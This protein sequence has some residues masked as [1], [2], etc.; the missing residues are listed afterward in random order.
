M[1]PS[2]H[3]PL[4]R[5]QPGQ[6]T[7]G[8]VAAGLGALLVLVAIVAGLPVLLSI[9]APAHLPTHAP[10]WGQIHDALLRPDDGSLFLGSLKVVAWTGWAWLVLAV[11]V[12]TLAALRGLPAPR[13]P[14]LG[15]AQPAAAS[16]IATITVLLSAPTGQTGTTA[17]ARAVATVL[18]EIPT[19]F[20]TDP[21]GHHGTLTRPAPP[22][23]APTS[24]PT[25]T[26]ASATSR[27]HAGEG[28]LE[29]TVHRGETLWSLAEKHLGD[30]TRF[31]EI[32]HANYGRPQPD[33]RT[34]TETH[35][36]RPGW[37]LRIPG[38]TQPAAQESSEGSSPGP[39]Q[40]NSVHDPDTTTYVVRPGDTLWDIAQTHL[41]DGTRYPQIAQD[42]RDITQPDGAHLQDPDLIRPG[43][44]LRLPHEQDH[45]AAGQDPAT[46][47]PKAAASAPSTA[48]GSQRWQLAIPDPVPSATSPA[49]GHASVP[50]PSAAGR[51]APVIPAHPGVPIVG[52]KPPAA[53]SWPASVPTG[54]AGSGVGARE[55]VSPQIPGDQDGSPHTDSD[56]EQGVRVPGGWMDYPMAAA[57]AI[58]A[59]RVWLW[60]RHRHAYTPEDLLTRPGEGDEDLVELPTVITRSR[61]VVRAHAPALLDPPDPGPTVAEYLAARRAHSA[62]SRQE[63]TGAIPGLV[64]PPVGPDALDLTGL[65]AQ[66][67]GGITLGGPGA[68]D[69]ARALLVAAVASGGVHDPFAGTQVVIP[70]DLASRLLAPPALATG[71]LASGS[72]PG[73]EAHEPAPS[74][75]EVPEVLGGVERAQVVADL[76]AGLAHVE[77]ELVERR[78]TL[79]AYQV[80]DRVELHETDP[81]AEPMPLLILLTDTPAPDLCERL[82]ALSGPGAPAGISIVVLGDQAWHPGT[83]VDVQ[84]DGHL[85][86]HEPSED[87]SGANG[88]GAGSRVAVLNIDAAWQALAAL[89][90]ARTGVRTPEPENVPRN[91][92][93]GS[94]GA[95]VI[96][97]MNGTAAQLVPSAPAEPLASVP[98]PSA[99]EPSAAGE[100]PGAG[101]VPD[102]RVRVRVLGSPVIWDRDGAPVT[103]M[104]SRAIEIMVLL[105]VRRAGSVLNNIMDALW[106]AAT[107]TQASQC[108]STE[109]ARLRKAIRQ[110]AGD[111]EIQPVVNTGS[112]YHLNPEVVRVDLWDFTDA[113]R[114]AEAEQI[115]GPGLS[116]PAGRRARRIAALREALEIADGQCLADGTKY[117]WIAGPRERVR[118]LLLR[119]HVTLV[120]LLTEAGEHAEAAQVVLAAVDLDPANEEI[121]R[122]A[123]SA[124]AAAGRG[125]EIPAQ[126]RRLRTV[127]ED[128]D[129]EPSPETTALAQRLDPGPPSPH[130]DRM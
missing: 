104:R 114:R 2:T 86:R 124:L 55:S 123:M 38:A 9:V 8:D 46:A 41:G 43:W 56:G 11:A 49:A 35:W 99:V 20:T 85:T 96:A 14:S 80:R 39:G 116:D 119:T 44:E 25:T 27:A 78:R 127:L 10:T 68:L 40:V 59:A 73:R 115:A 19:A 54:R 64:L 67:R 95:G 107:M 17:P 42:S 105:S 75:E 79:A 94:H 106:P 50:E 18:H 102:Q 33:G 13:H 45:P 77:R 60:R 12:E 84:A 72:G 58:L 128:L 122:T 30:G 92:D 103:H 87:P 111:P 66:D 90:E 101:P 26:A 70:A 47:P 62:G 1:S 130:G 28:G 91:P 98:G 121:T 97:A 29:V 23:P 126:L 36:I 69:A 125:A 34:L 31:R 71:D 22:S 15:L 117:E 37:T 48:P 6:R 57:L 21:A 112:H 16:L 108:L 24:H 61:A 53:I 63:R 32:A 89:R 7:G 74:G 120:D 113:L 81:L 3:R 118:R 5:T 109:T 51:A 82:A 93:P 65:A 110:V 76:P 52:V 129:L 88:N 100:D 4:P 83:S